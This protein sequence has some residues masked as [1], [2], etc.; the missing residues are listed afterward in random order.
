MFLTSKIKPQRNYWKK[1]VWNRKNQ[2]ITIQSF[3]TSCIIFIKT[4]T[5]KAKRNYF[6]EIRKF[7]PIAAEAVKFNEPTSISAKILFKNYFS[8]Q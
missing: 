5:V 2:D 7:E 1:F 4:E 6:S 3:T 8:F